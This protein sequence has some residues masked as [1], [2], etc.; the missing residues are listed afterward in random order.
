M[1]LPDIVG[2]LLAVG[3]WCNHARMKKFMI[4][5]VVEVLVVVVA[6]SSFRFISERLLAAAVAGT[7]FVCL[8]LA[9]FIMG[10]RD[11]KFRKTFTFTIGCVH[12]FA[13]ALPMMI[14]RFLNTT[15]A[16]SQVD[17]WGLPGP[18][19]HKLSTYVYFALMLGAIADGVLARRRNRLQAAAR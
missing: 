12:L 3:V 4:L 17:I 13:V 6:M 19:F 2:H 10:I 16:F 11:A 1:N 5:L 18:V 15:S 9:I 14:V 8:G 7:V